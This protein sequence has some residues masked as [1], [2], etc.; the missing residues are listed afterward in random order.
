MILVR[1][2]LRELIHRWLNMLLSLIAV[3][4]A[5]ALYVVFY[6][7]GEAADRETTRIMRDLGY[8]LRII[9]KETD[10]TQ[11]WAQGY[12]SETMPEEYVQR[13]ATAENI[14]YRHLL[15]TLHRQ[16]PA[17]EGT[18]LLTGIGTE[19]SPPGFKKSSMIFTVEPGT[20]YA[21]YH[22]AQRLNLREGEETEILGRRFRVARCLSET[23]SDE[24]VRVYGDLTE[25]QEMLGLEGQINEIQALECLCHGKEEDMI[26]QLRAELA[27]LLPE[28]K[29]IELL[30][31]AKIRQKQRIMVRTYYEFFMQMIL[32]VCALWLAVL[33]F[34]N[35]RERRGEIGLLHA[36]GYGTATIAL[37]V[38]GKWAL[39][40]LAGA[41][42]GFLM[43][44][45]LSLS[46]GPEIFHITA[47]GIE[48]VYSLLSWALLIAPLFT[49]LCGSV[50]AVL[51][52]TQDPA[53][54]LLED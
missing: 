46:V 4:T 15:A 8:N 10:E 42:F 40:G 34:L 9:P 49:M 41:L 2:V 28:A 51:A 12:A 13:F 30:S 22:A 36:L 54:A 14:S 26:G 27:E 18:V 33:A 38:L 11:F 21:G 29:V 5:V 23:G 52:V 6:T 39:I 16:V 1:L 7:T 35:V 19:V 32:V 24:D 25:V 17:G 20:I 53:Q 44:T 37:L 45:A 43:G 50:P 48:P 47:A 31:L 3:V